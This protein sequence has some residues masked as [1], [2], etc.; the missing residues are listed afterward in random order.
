MK[1]TLGDETIEVK[2]GSKS[3][4]KEEAAKRMV[5]LIGP[6]IKDKEWEKNSAELK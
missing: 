3:E 5:A 1:L 4:G 2:C 6:F